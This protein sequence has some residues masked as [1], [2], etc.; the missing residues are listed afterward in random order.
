VNQN[1]HA[2]VGNVTATGDIIHYHS[3]AVRLI[4]V[5]EQAVENAPEIPEPEKRS[6]LQRL[7]AFAEDPYVSGLATS[8]IYEGIKGLIEQLSK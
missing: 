2:Q 6:L 1:F 8:A 5:L 3:G 4:Q 7:R